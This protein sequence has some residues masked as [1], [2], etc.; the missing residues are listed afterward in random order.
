MRGPLRQKTNTVALQSGLGL[1]NVH[2]RIAFLQ[3]RDVL[4]VPELSLQ[5]GGHLTTEGLDPIL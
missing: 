2:G 1:I 4:P 5:E 3:D